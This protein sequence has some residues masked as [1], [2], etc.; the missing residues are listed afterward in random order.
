MK[1]PAYLLT[2]P[3]L[4]FEN[5]GRELSIAHSTLLNKVFIFP[6]I[7]DEWQVGIAGQAGS[8]DSNRVC[9]ELQYVLEN[10]FEQR[11]N[12]LVTIILAD[13]VSP[14]DLPAFLRGKQ[15]YSW[16]RSAADHHKIACCIAGIEEIVT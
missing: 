10:M 7:C 15:T 1:C 16:P 5:W 14:C 3:A 11:L 4:L 13:D 2:H 8:N 9:L 12:S 6:Q